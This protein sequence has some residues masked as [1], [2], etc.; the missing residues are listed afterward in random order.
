L[1]LLR[2]QYR[3]VKVVMNE[4]SNQTVSDDQQPG[5]LRLIGLWP[6]GLYFAFCLVLAS[7][8]EVWMRIVDDLENYTR[9]HFRRGLSG[10][11]ILSGVHFGQT[12]G[13]SSVLALIAGLCGLHAIRSIAIASIL[14]VVIFLTL[15]VD[16]LSD[17]GF[18]RYS[19]LFYAYNL[20]LMVFGAAIPLLAAR[21]VSGAVITRQS[22][23]DVTRRLSVESLLQMTTVVACLMFFCRVPMLLHR[24]TLTQV[25]PYLPGL[26]A[27]SA[28]A[29]LITVLPSVRWTFQSRLNWLRW[30][31]VIVISGL[32]VSILC[33][34]YSVLLGSWM[35]GG[36]FSFGPIGMMVSVIF[37][38]ALYLPGII[39]LRASG[40]LWQ[41]PLVASDQ[42]L[43]DSSEW[44]QRRTEWLWTGGFLLAAASTTMP[45]QALKRYEKIRFQESIQWLTQLRAEGGMPVGLRVSSAL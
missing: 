16:M 3:V 28:L 10:N 45:I 40:Y 12:M 8:Q 15:M 20:P 31:L 7:N 6:L 13:V 41:K 39:A 22:K 38:M 21:A 35:G 36:G 30:L 23:V 1:K 37:F 42:K 33:G 19:E 26:L 29:S 14:A 34:A 27:M 9:N 32:G 24:L 4:H 17:Q 43:S 11:Q 18:G 5:R 2:S 44:S 25:L